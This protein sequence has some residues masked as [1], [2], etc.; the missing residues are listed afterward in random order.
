M[1]NNYL[2]ITVQVKEKMILWTDEENFTFND[3]FIKFNFRTDDNLVYDE[4]L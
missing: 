2:K 4:I 1:I 3:D